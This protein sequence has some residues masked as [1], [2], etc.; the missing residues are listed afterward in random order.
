VHLHA[1]HR[2]PAIG[3]D[4]NQVRTAL[5]DA[6]EEFIH[7]SFRDRDLQ[8]HR[9]LGTGFAHRPL[10][11]G[12]QISESQIS[13][14]EDAALG[15]DDLIIC[16]IPASGREGVEGIGLRHTDGIN[17]HPVI[18]R[19]QGNDI[20]ALLELE[21]DFLNGPAP[22]ILQSDENRVDPRLAITGNRDAGIA[23]AV[24]AYRT[25]PDQ[26][27]VRRCD[28]G[29]TAVL[30]AVFPV[31]AVVHPDGKITVCLFSELECQ[32]RAGEDREG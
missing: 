29:L 26:R 1:V 23:E 2:C 25:M 10:L 9:H 15:L 11:T 18:A 21:A 17:Q 30:A 6:G 27:P 32:H 16:W 13:L 22:V 28:H 20:L 12:I 3:T 14:R 4:L 19:L 5:P 7:P 31:R 8:L 24:S